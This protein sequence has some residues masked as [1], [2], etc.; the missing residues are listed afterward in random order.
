M[1][2]LCFLAHRL[3][4]LFRPRVFSRALGSL[5]RREPAGTPRR[6]CGPWPTTVAR[7]LRVQSRKSPRGGIPS[8]WGHPGP[9]KLT[10]RS[11]ECPTAHVISGILNVINVVKHYLLGDGKVFPDTN[12]PDMRP[13]LIQ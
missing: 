1:Y 9:C 7:V 5:A 3:F 2:K 13:L 12:M 10:Y 8:T 6:K 11:K 4:F